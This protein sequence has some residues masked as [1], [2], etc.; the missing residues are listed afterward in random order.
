MGQTPLIGQFLFQAST[1]FSFWRRCAF[2]YFYYLHQFQLLA[3][4][5][6]CSIVRMAS[7]RYI[8]TDLSVKLWLSDY[9]VLFLYH[10]GINCPLFMDNI[11]HFSKKAYQIIICI[12]IYMYVI[13]YYIYYIYNIITHHIYNHNII[14]LYQYQYINIKYNIISYHWTI[15]SCI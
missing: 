10:S 11:E 3:C 6:N 5:S 4:R 2:E 1:W 15:V 12:W 13:Y 14:L 9:L 7:L 8:Q